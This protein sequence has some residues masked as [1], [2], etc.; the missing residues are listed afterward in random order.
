MARLKGS[1][2]MR[3]QHNARYRAWQSMRMLRRFSIPDL[4]ATAEISNAN[5][6][7]YVRRLLHAGYLRVAQEK[8]SGIAG[9]H[10]VYQLIRNTGPSQPRCRS[11][12]TLYDPNT[13]EV[14]GDE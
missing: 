6:S 2:T 11:N 12:G 13:G 5:V 1:Y 14:T 7:K 9:G 8:R 3:A 4:V 10:T